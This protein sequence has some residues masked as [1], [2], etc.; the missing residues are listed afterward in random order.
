MSRALGVTAG[1]AATTRLAMTVG[2]TGA[3][4]PDSEANWNGGPFG[5]PYIVVSG[6]QGK[7]PV[8]FD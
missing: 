7:V 2:A 5:I 6:T 3:F 8:S 4:H 1:D